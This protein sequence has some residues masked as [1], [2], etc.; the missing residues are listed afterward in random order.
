MPIRRRRIAGGEPLGLDARQRAERERRNQGGDRV[1]AEPPSERE[2]AEPRH[3][4]RMKSTITPVPT[5]C[6]TSPPTPRRFIGNSHG[7]GKPITPTAVSAAAATRNGRLPRADS[8]T[9][10]PKRDREQVVER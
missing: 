3:S 8:Q 9:P 5:M 6:V 7:P 10:T 4:V 1:D 2:G